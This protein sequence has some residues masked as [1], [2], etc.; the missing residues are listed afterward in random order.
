LHQRIRLE[1]AAQGGVV[2]PCSVIVEPEGRLPPL[3]GEA[4][5]GGEKSTLRRNDPIRQVDEGAGAG[6]YAC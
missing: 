1:E 2:E 3:A 4:A 6:L 5:V